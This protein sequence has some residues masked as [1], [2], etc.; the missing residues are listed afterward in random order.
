MTKEGMPCVTLRDLNRTDF[1]HLFDWLAA[2]HIVRWWG[3]APDM[4]ALIAK[5]SPRLA[6]DTTTKVYIIEA[7]GQ[8][9]GLIQCYR[10]ADHPDYDSE[11]GIESAAGIDY[12]VGEA[13][14]TGKGIG[15][16]AIKKVARLALELYPEINTVLSI[17]QKENVASCRALE[18]AG[19]RLIEERQL[20]SENLLE[21]LSCI[22]ALETP[23]LKSLEAPFDAGSTESGN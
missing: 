23:L 18:K 5:Y 2:P 6:P 14:C 21:G 1:S 8:P 16:K 10:H 7:G 9:V 22:Y 19:F 4:E 20:K 11:V 12:F 13:G 15:T 17:P 3:E